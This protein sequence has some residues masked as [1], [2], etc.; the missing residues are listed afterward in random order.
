MSAVND[1]NNVTSFAAII[2]DAAVSHA[3]FSSAPTISRYDETHLYGAV[4]DTGCSRASSGGFS[5]YRAYC[6]QSGVKEEID[7]KNKVYCRFG[8][9]G[10]MSLGRARIN[11]PVNGIILP[12]YVHVIDVHLPILLSLAHMDRLHVICNNLQN[13]LIHFPSK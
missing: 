4:I 1:S 2:R 7:T 10:T 3:L 9:T 8:L 6:R 11:F 5:Q 13:A 12:F